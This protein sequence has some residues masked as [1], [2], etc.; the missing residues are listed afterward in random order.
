MIIEIDKEEIYWEQ[1]ARVNWLR[2]GDKNTAFFHIFASHKRSINRVEGLF[3]ENGDLVS[4]DVEMEKIA[5]RYFEDL[6]T[7][8]GITLT[9]CLLEGIW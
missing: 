7:S 8:K 6:F 4:D 1:R 2:K 3:S 9:D 5:R